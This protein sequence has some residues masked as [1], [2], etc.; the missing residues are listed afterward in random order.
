MVR[1]GFVFLFFT[2]SC[3]FSLAQVVPDTTHI[4]IGDKTIIVIDSNPTD[5]TE[6]A[7]PGTIDAPTTP[8]S[9]IKNQLTHF[10]GIDFGFCQLIDANGSVTRDS[11]TNWLSINN[12][13]SLTWRFNLIEKK[14]RIYRD[15]IGIYTGFAIA[16]NSYGFSGNVDVVSDNSEE[17]IYTVAV[18]PQVRN[19]HKNKLRTTILQVP[20]MLEFNTRD[21]V[22][23]NIN[24]AFG[25]IGGYVS[26]TITKQKWENDLG[27]FTNR[28]REEFQINPWTLDFSIRIGFR[29][30]ALF[31][32]YGLTPLFE[33]NRGSVV[34]PITFGVQLLQF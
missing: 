16:Y 34:Y 5:K 23:K 30:T 21:E 27:K 15:Y 8:E 10:A 31:F 11:A 3:L 14:I 26:S 2:T 20:L 7:S 17:G 33:K 19:Y 28:R 22:K 13:Q 4:S 6:P 29:K 18:D 12:G 9:E 1:F 25:V 24:L 32:N